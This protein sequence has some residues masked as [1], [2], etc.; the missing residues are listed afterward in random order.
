M[1]LD[2][3][4]GDLFQEL[5]NADSKATDND[6]AIF[7]KRGEDPDGVVAAF[8]KTLPRHNPS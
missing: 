5:Y 8:M 7:K 1:Q 6:W 4:W 2:S 3:E